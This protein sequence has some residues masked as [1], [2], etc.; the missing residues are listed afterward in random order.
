MLNCTK[1]QQR[2]SGKL[3][4]CPECGADQPSLSKVGPYEIL[5]CV[6][7]SRTAS[8]FRAARKDAT[9]EVVCLRLYDADVTISPDQEKTLRARFAGLRELPS[10]R[11]VHTLDFGKDTET[12]RWYRVT[13]WLPNVM[14]W[15]DL[16]S[17]ALYRN[18][19]RKRQWL[20]LAL[21]LAESFAA[22][23]RIGRVI[24]D[25]TLDDCLLYR[26]GDGRLRVRLDATLASCL[27]PGSGREKVRDRH[28]DF[29]AG[30]T[31]SEQSD[32]WTLGSIL[33]GMLKGT[34][35]IA[36]YAKAM[37]EIN[38]ERRPVAL[39]PELGA[40]LR[41]M[42]DTDPA[43]RPRGMKQV[44][45]RL[46]GFGPRE[47]GEWC[48]LDNQHRVLM[49]RIG[50]AAAA[51]VF[52]VVVTT[53]GLYLRQSRRH[54]RDL[55][56]ARADTDAAVAAVER[57]VQDG[58]GYID[59]KTEESVLTMLDEIRRS[60]PEARAQAVLERYGRSVAFVLVESWI[61]ALGRRHTMNVANG[62]AFLAS[63]DGHLL[64]NRHVVMP[65][66]DRNIAARIQEQV[67]FCRTHN[68]PF[69]FGVTYYL[70]F[71]G[72][73][74]FRHLHTAASD[75]V[76]DQFRLD[77]AYS[78]D[79]DDRQVQLLGV[80]P[81]PGDRAE[82]LASQLKNDIAV[83]KINPL[84]EG[85]VPI[86]LR[87]GPPS[88]LGTEALV[89][90]YPHGRLAISGMTAKARYSRGAI[91]STP[92]DILR[93]NADTHPGNSGGPVLD[94][95]GYVIGIA[96]AIFGFSR[97]NSETE[98]F[99]VVVPSQ[100]SMGFVEPIAKARQFLD[101]VRAG[102]PAWNG[103]LDEAFESE[104]TVARRAVGRG[105]WEEAAEALFKDERIF[106]VPNLALDAAV[107]SLTDA[108][109]SPAG[110]RALESVV[111]IQPHQPLPA[112]LRY[113][114]AWRNE[115]PVAKRPHRN[116]FLN[117]EWH[118]PF[119]PIG[120]VVRLL[121]GEVT[122][123]DALAVA[124]TQMEM[125]LLLW[126]G[127]TAAAQ[128]GE[129]TLA[130]RHLQDALAQTGADDTLLRNL[131]AVTLLRECEMLPESLETKSGAPLPLHQ[132][133]YQ[134]LNAA[135][136]GRWRAAVQAGERYFAVPHRP[137]SANSLRM[138]LLRA[139]VHGLMGNRTAERQA[140]EQFRGRIAND[141]Y[142]QIA[143]ALLGN[144]D[145]DALLAS[146]AGK[147]HETLTLAVA[148]GLQAEVRKD[149]QRAL[150]YYRTALDTAQTNW[151]EFQLARARRQ[152]VGGE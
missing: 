91:S 152:G 6:A 4:A 135:A 21:D 12:G 87:E 17:E 61:H 49:R 96:S 126:A 105:A 33:V 3:K 32:V 73:E 123:D 18:R 39:H 142:K 38:A 122:L 22:L 9:A 67:D 60:S 114:D 150:N 132:F 69:R 81:F 31:L 134:A 144:T 117:A 136:D 139:Q 24:P 148:L 137:E 71:D 76:A 36:D 64:S 103:L 74:A 37:D 78:S 26:A 99:E 133:M 80:M 82:F 121:E 11:F 95:E 15:G 97:F 90:G 7:D 119:E 101:H 106:G 113:W 100:P 70:W 23:H 47:I 62:T 146:V 65:W 27:G 125:T 109:F 129:K 59:A 138:G 25:F 102:A 42:V 149:K 14:A 86:P 63:S 118:S 51:A 83:L 53:V 30:R 89:L 104:I 56:Q 79:S 128:S 107:Y 28:P 151:L 29:A 85:A 94:L 110:R 130:A 116:A 16:K 48:V 93:I 19:E 84:P 35:D 13:P 46:R 50:L 120:Q 124:E 2:L 68:I 34:S 44:A 141:W 112:L 5:E 111:A 57:Q 10:E 98:T 140:L 20:G 54:Q 145:P 75:S 147:R 40:L 143:D 43:E 77:T 55:S 1:C 108:G 41:Q 131:L 45:E 8:I 72:D 92:D 127:G 88:A 115:A 58:K 66:E 52:A